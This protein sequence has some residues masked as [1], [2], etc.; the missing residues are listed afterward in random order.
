MSEE[1]RIPAY[2]PEN[3]VWVDRRLTSS[4]HLQSAL[5]EFVPSTLAG[6]RARTEFVKRRL[7]L[8][9]GL[10]PKVELPVN[11]AQ[12]S[13]ARIYNGVAIKYVS[14]ATLPGVRLTGSLFMPEKLDAPAPGVLCPH[15]HWK[16][17]RIHHAPNGGVVM[18]CFQLARLGF[19]V[20]AYDMIG[21]NE[22]NDFPHV[23]RG[24]LK[25]K[26]DLAGVYS[27]GLQTVNSMRAVDF[28][29]SLD[30]VDEK[31]I[32]CTGASGGASQTWFIS[33]LDERIKVVV[34][35]CMLSSHFQGGCPCEEGPLLRVTGLTSFDIVSAVAPRPVL[36]P[37]VTGD[38]TNLNP[39]YEIPRLKSIYK[40][41]NAEN[42]VSSLYFEDVHNYNRRTREYAYAF[43]VKHLMGEDRGETIQEED[44]APPPPELL[45]ETGEN[46]APA[47]EESALA[48]LAKAERAYNADVLKYTDFEA[49]KSE[50]RELLRE[51]LES[52]TPAV[53]DVVERVLYE[54]IDIPGA[55]FRGVT[56]SRR[57]VG[58]LVQAVNVTPE[59]C[60]DDGSI[61][62]LISDSEY[63]DYLYD[64]SKS[65]YLQQLVSEKRRIRIVELTGTGSTRWQLKYDLRDTGITGA[66]FDQSTFAMRVEDIITACTVLKER[67][68]SDIK[69]IAE[70]GAVPAA[71]AACALLDM[72]L[73]ADFEAVDESVWDDPVN[74]HPLIGRIGGISG[75]KLLNG[76]K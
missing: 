33:A 24:E 15:G 49:Y 35:V 54:E 37:G 8:S 72:P 32:A 50:R 18:R 40:L 52:R 3:P 43:L 11:P 62:L 7:L 61:T 70:K 65:G 56:M 17:G 27:F 29:S 1:K 47:T 75:L 19:V 45:W 46:P 26:G 22:N 12:I 10:L 36:R 21:Y 39:D 73:E 67:G 42:R 20:F 74:H 64:G 63:R 34:P 48:A 58:D 28:I 51:I 23:W 55:K 66:A 57:G 2:I 6:H 53:V 59:G 14:I 25:R 9:A 41:Y 76:I 68:Y 30:E 16:T 69:I 5:D 71:L 4:R 13:G 38:W 44:I 31:R 60:A